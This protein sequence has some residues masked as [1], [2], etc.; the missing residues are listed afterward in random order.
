MSFLPVAVEC[1]EQ[2][3]SLAAQVSELA[4]AIFSAKAFIGSLVPP[5]YTKAARRIP[6]TARSNNNED[7]VTLLCFPESEPS[8]FVFFAVE[9]FLL[10][11]LPFF[12]AIIVYASILSKSEPLSIPYLYLLYKYP[13]N[14]QSYM[15]T[16]STTL[17]FDSHSSH[18][19]AVGAPVE[20]DSDTA[21]AKAARGS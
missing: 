8:V 5:R 1:S 6:G 16:L 12:A 13:F 7:M 20:I 2:L 4:V 21:L 18:N 17:S 19:A 14:V 15:S 9:A 3:A 10:L 11:L